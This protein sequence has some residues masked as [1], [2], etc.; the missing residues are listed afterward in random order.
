PR[1]YGTNR[2]RLHEYLGDRRFRPDAPAR[3]DRGAWAVLCPLQGTDSVRPVFLN[4]D[5]LRW[6]GPGESLVGPLPT[7]AV[8]SRAIERC[9]LQE[10]PRVRYL[11]YTSR[12]G[13]SS[14]SGSATKIERWL[15]P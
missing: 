3:F 2:N 15:T 5:D 11:A 1:R 13:T 9:T 6:V 4:H 10:A 7:G 14:S 8:L 12:R